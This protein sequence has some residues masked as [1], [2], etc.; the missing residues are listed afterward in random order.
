MMPKPR[1][2]HLNEVEEY[3]D[4]NDDDAEEG[5]DGD[6][7]DDGSHEVGEGVQPLGYFK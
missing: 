1:F 7:Q 4:G 3:G 5:D 2:T 6:D